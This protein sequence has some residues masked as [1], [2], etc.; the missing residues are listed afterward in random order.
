MNTNTGSNVF[1]PTFSSDLPVASEGAAVS[2]LAITYAPGT[3]VALGAGVG[4]GKT[5]TAVQI[6]LAAMNQGVKTE[7]YN[8]DNADRWM[9]R[10]GFSPEQ[11]N[12]VVVPYSSAMTI[13]K[14]DAKVVIYDNT[15]STA[16]LALMMETLQRIAKER[17]IMVIA[18]VQ[19]NKAGNIASENV[20]MHTANAVAILPSNRPGREVLNL[21]FDIP[22]V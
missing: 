14:T 3:L 1:A 5:L 21:S 4:Q 10:M 15:G 8:S 20:V 18:M 16:S 12:E 17:H 6:A 13:D 11:V 19:L 2:S 7:I 22:T 9:E